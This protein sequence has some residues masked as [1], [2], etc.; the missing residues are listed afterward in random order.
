VE[1]DKDEAWHLFTEM[2]V[3]RRMETMANELYRAKHIRGFCHLYS[4]QEA[5]CVGMAS[6]LR[7]NDSITTAYRCHGWARSLG[8]APKAIFGELFG[9]CAPDE[10]RRGSDRISCAAGAGCDAHLHPSPISHHPRQQRRLLQGQ[11]WL[12]AHVRHQLLRRQRYRRRPGKKCVPSSA[13]KGSRVRS[14][15][16]CC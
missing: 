12:Y 10:E 7:E 14:S 3:I 16:H 6:E 15:V 4:G 2:S 5:V 13:R 8:W 11:R 1:L 9:A